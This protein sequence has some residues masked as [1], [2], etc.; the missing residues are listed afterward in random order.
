MNQNSYAGINVN[1]WIIVLI[2]ENFRI[3]ISLSPYT[4]WA[5]YVPWADVGAGVV[6]VVVVA[7]GVVAVGV[8]VLVVVAAGVEGVLPLPLPP[9]LLRPLPPPLPDLLITWHNKKNNN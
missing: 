5:R 6:V 1:N 2:S 9:P 3:Y 7:V 8:V 4:C